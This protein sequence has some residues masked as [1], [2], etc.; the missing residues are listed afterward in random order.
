[1]KITPGGVGCLFLNPIASGHELNVV[2]LQSRDALCFDQNKKVCFDGK[3]GA[4]TI[5]LEGEISGY[6]G[7]I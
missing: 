4:R 3:R 2:A 7:V 1:M 5:Q 6:L